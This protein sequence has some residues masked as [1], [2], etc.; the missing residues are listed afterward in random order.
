M[1]NIPLISVCICCYNHS[2]F[3]DFCIKS[4]YEQD[5]KNIEI[6][7]LDDGSSD[8]SVEVI[9]NL[10]KD[11]PI[12]ITTIFQ[13]NSGCIGANFNKLLDLASGKYVSIISAD[14]ALLPNAFSKKIEIMEKDDNVQFVINSQIQSIDE[15]NKYSFDVVPTMR[16]DKISEPCAEDILN[17]E[18]NDIHSYYLQGS[19]FRKSIVDAVGRFDDDMIAD[20]IVLRT[21]LARYLQ[22]HPQMKFVTLHEKACLYRQHTNNVSKNSF[23]QM[24]SVLQ[25]FERYWPDRENSKELIDWSAGFLKKEPLEKWYDFF[26]I[27]KRSLSLLK[28][29]EVL[30]LIC[31][32]TYTDNVLIKIPFILE[33]NK[34]KNLLTRDK[35]VSIKI[36]GIKFKINYKKKRK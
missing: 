8:N 1:C 11:S 23:R 5:Y 10:Q 2:E 29:K 26:S 19:V 14:D 9:K 35:E 4:I 28:E 3:L 22:N 31:K 25:Y 17:L 36:F 21:K 16:L 13:E 15:N 32:I 7:I 12:K 27:N 30:N 20:D 33:L 24:K 34:R 6:L 18:F